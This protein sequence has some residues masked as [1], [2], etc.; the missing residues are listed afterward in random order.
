MTKKFGLKHLNDIPSFEIE[1]Y[2]KKRKDSGKADATMNCE[3]QALRDLLNKA[4]AWRK[5][6]HNPV[7]QVKLR[8]EENSRVRFLSKG[9]D[10]S[11]LRACRPNLRAVVIAA[12]N[13]GFRRGE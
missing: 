4:I 3:L 9:K 7:T 5:G 6:Q 10:T 8:K 1:K 11:L 13:T 2:R 12:L